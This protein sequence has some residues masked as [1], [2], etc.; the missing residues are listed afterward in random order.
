MKPLQCN[1]NF[2]PSWWMKRNYLAWLLWPFSQLFLLII[3]V[4]RWLYQK[5]W[6]KSYRAKLPVIVVGNITVGGTGKTPVVIAIAQWLKQQGLR[7]GIVSRGYKSHVKNYPY[8]VTAVSLAEQVG[9]E[10]LLIVQRTECPLV[11]DPIR[12]RAVQALE[13]SGK[14]DV[15]ISDDGL[16]HYALERDIEVVVI[17]GERRF[18]NGFLLPA[19][20][21]R[22]PTS[23]C[24]N[25]D[26]VVC[27]GGVAQ[28]K[29]WSM[30]LAP[31]KVYA[32]NNPAKT[33]SL[34][35]F[36]H[37]KVHAVAGIGNPQRFFALLRQAGLEVIEHAFPDHHAYTENDFNFVSDN[38]P[39][40]MTEKDAVKCPFLSY[41]E[42]WCVAVDAQ[43]PETFFLQL[44]EL[45]NTCFH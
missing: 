2:F 38:L 41:T 31:T 33:I 6:L 4:R 37:K 42:A 11:I 17:D 8:W 45:L 29:E 3:I 7:P 30:Q 9:D 25:V 40:F 35:H 39:V 32:V 19:G 28:D 5:Q 24:D 21:L 22:E 43:L 15:I 10:P 18:G 23:C 16:Q 36:Q 44:K 1:M 26:I 13:K 14:C 34:T 12:A 20:M 27:N